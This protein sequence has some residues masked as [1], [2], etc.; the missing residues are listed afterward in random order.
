MR[1]PPSWEEGQ[2]VWL[3]PGQVVTET[4]EAQLKG[5]SR[6]SNYAAVMTVKQLGDL[7]AFLDEVD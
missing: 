3:G 4:E 6:M 5:V 1:R 7:V 2:R